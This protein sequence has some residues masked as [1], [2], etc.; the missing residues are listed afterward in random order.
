MPHLRSLLNEVFITER[1][2]SGDLFE[3]APLLYSEANVQNLRVVR[4]GSRLVGHAGILPR[5]IRWRGQVFQVGLIGGVCARQEL[6]GQGIGT[7][8]MEDAAR[9]ME[10]IGLDFG[11]LW[12]GSPGFYERLG[13]RTAGGICVMGMQEAADTEIELHFEIMPLAESPFDPAKCHRLHEQAARNEVVRT[14]EETE[15]LLSIGGRETFIALRGGRL[16][17]YAVKTGETIREI[18]GDAA[19]CIALLH[20][21][22]AEGAR[23]CIFARSDPRIDAIEGALPVNLQR[24]PLG[25]VLIV[26]RASLLAKIA[27][28]TGRSAGELGLGDDLSDDDLIARVFGS[29]EDEPSEEPL[30]VDVHIDYL[31]HV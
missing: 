2:S 9:R 8:A 12:T 30:P 15:A 5:P 11:V 14:C 29:P 27:D 7:I 6:R 17:G 31:D 3:F 22:A 25:M 19:I 23:Q 26:D 16:G 10:E 20:H 18:E 21:L 24:R 28:E 13:W 1:D 4:S